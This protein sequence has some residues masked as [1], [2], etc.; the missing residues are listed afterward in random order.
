MIA[1]SSSGTGFRALATYLAQGRTGME[2]GRIAWV[3][4]RNLPT[5]DLQIAA[6]LMRATAAQNVRIEQPVY[7]LALALDPHDP[8]DRVVLE[9]VADQVL[10]RLGLDGHQAVIAAHRDREH[11]HVHVLVNR[12]HPE[13]GR[14]WDRWH[15]MP[16]IQRVL[17]EEELALGLRV[18]RGHLHSLTTVEQAP[19]GHESPRPRGGVD[20]G[21]A[22]L[23]VEDGPT[24][25]KPRATP[26]LVERARAVVPGVREATSWDDVSRVLDEAGLRL[27]RRGSGL[28]ITDGARYAKA[29]RVA[30]EMTLR[31]L[32]P[33]LG[34]MN[35]VAVQ[36]VHERAGV[37]SVSPERAPV[38]RARGVDAKASVGRPVA[39]RSDTLTRIV[40]DIARLERVRSV[41]VVQRAEGQADGVARARA[42]QRTAAQ[43]RHDRTSSALDAALVRAF[44]DPTTARTAIQNAARVE[45]TDAAVER[46]RERPESFG[47]LVSVERSRGFG[48]VRDR[49]DSVARL[50]AREA[51]VLVRDLLV[52][53]RGVGT[54]GEHS[55]DGKIIPGTNTGLVERTPSPTPT[56]ATERHASSV[57]DDLARG[58]REAVRKLTPAEVRQLH[59]MLTRPQVALA[60]RLRQ[61]V[62]DA[63]LGHEQD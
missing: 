55:T 45:G 29:S 52:A 49:D 33:R 61:T 48:L 3:T 40:E 56:R 62:R 43:D 39:E 37:D 47:A 51:A 23:P 27:E 30:P 53:Q 41:A 63:V 46:L 15:D 10:A 60:M 59:A 17:R 44:A 35:S 7:H 57:V 20:D 4:P 38:E 9:R 8:A 25:R 19:I 36:D 5:A 32:E 22:M 14:A 6:T 18:V 12:V 31:M 58:I 11:P 13:T 2:T 42:N 16:T 34:A 24:S 1:V 26:T 54:T 28:V 50:A 21:A